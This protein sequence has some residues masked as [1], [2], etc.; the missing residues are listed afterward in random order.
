LTE[1]ALL[2]GYVKHQPSRASDLGVSIGGEKDETVLLLHGGLS[3]SD[4]M[5]DPLGQALGETYR[6]AAFDRRG[7]GRTADTSEPFH[8]DTMADET[9][10]FVEDL[11]G[12]VH[13]VGWSDG[14]NVGLLVALRLGSSDS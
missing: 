4:A 8:Y 12:P 2:C 1:T 6:V 13:L 5:L 14:G 11:G 10:A 7:H 3:N 9:L